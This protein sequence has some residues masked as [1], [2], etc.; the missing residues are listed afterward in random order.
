MCER[1]IR[2]RVAL[3]KAGQVARGETP[4]QLGAARSCRPPRGGVNTIFLG[5]GKIIKPRIAR[6]SALQPDCRFEFQKSG[7]LFLRSHNETL[8]VVSMCVCNPDRSPIGI[9][10]CNAA[11]ASTGFAGIVSDDFPVLHATRVLRVII[12]RRRMSRRLLRN[13]RN[14][15]SFCM[16]CMDHFLCRYCIDE[17]WSSAG[18][19]LLPLLTRSR[20][21]KRISWFQ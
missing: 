9:H 18:F 13:V 8:S 3:R 11:P 20:R 21:G 16:H 12:C 5:N 7:Q 1:T 10:C 17:F 6:I 15:D 4:K 19:W 2:S 14:T